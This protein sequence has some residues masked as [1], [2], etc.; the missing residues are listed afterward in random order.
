MDDG[1]L[2]LR[3]FN[4]TYRDLELDLTDVKQLLIVEYQQKRKDNVNY[5]CIFCGIGLH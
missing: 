4:P 5:I 3:S 1:K 2:I